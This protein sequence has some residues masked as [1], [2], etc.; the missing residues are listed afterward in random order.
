MRLWHADVLAEDGVL[1]S[2]ES[3]TLERLAGARM[4]TNA[5]VFQSALADGPVTATKSRGNLPWSFV[6]RMLDEMSW[7]PVQLERLHLRLHL[8]DKAFYNEE[9]A[10]DLKELRAV[11]RVA[12]HLKKRH[13]RLVRRDRRTG[14]LR[15]R[16]VRGRGGQPAAAYRGQRRSDR[17]GPRLLRRRVA[18]RPPPVLSPTMCAFATSKAEGPA[19]R[20]RQARRSPSSREPAS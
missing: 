6:K 20:T 13:G 19:T 3:T 10:P 14:R 4:L 18:R 17:R 9:E 16:R 15:P 8:L 1:R 11:L 5:R 7:K 2:D 12:G